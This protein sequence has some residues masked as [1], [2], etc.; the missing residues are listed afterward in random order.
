MSH[1][2]STYY[3]NSVYLGNFSGE[4]Y[5]SPLTI[6]TTGVIYPEPFTL[7]SGL[8]GAVTGY[9]TVINDGTIHGGDNARGYYFRGIELNGIITN[10]GLIQ[11]G[12]GYLSS[13]ASG[14]GGDG[15]QLLGGGTVTNFGTI[16]GGMN[17]T[18]AG[19]GVG[20]DIQGVITNFGTVIGG[21]AGYGVIINGGTIEASGGDAVNGLGDSAVVIDPGGV[22]IGEVLG[23]VLEVSGTSAET[24]SGIGTQFLDF[25]TIDF[26]L[27]AA[28]AIEG[29]VTALDSGQVINGFSLNDTIFAS[30]FAATSETYVANT[31]LEI[32]DGT[33]TATLD[34]IGSFST[35]LFVVTSAG[36]QTEV[37]LLCYL[38]STNIATPVGEVPVETLKIGDAVITRFSG[39][40]KVKWIGR[41]SFAARFV[42]N[43]RDQI[44]VRFAIGALGPNLPKRDLFVSPGHSMLIGGV[45]VLARNLVN[46]VTITQDDLPEEIHYYQLEFEGHDC[47][48]AEGAW[49]ESFCDY[50]GLRNQFHNVDSFY[51][52]YPDHVTPDEHRMCAP[53]PEAGP[54]LEAALLPVVQRATALAVPGALHGWI[55]IVDTFGRVEGWAQDTANPELPVLLDLMVNSEK[56]GRTLACEYRVDLAAAGLGKGC[57]AFAFDAAAE[58][59][60]RASSNVQVRR[61]TDMAEIKMGPHCLASLG[62]LNQPTRASAES[63]AYRRIG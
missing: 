53:R 21:V 17:A 57:C 56:R 50:A 55:D 60:F 10:H 39:Y 28:W 5:R 26:N 62:V 1:T 23:D 40:Q 22:F 19:H 25:H 7:Y 37:E 13:G 16:V 4:Q 33:A 36:D 48:L 54:M 58:M 44:P 34:I 12:N 3:G 31:G 6:T 35:G 41:Q 61:S 32:S 51:L 52:L 8:V 14:L 18:G 49:S 29:T 46:G 20:I 45:L 47:V 27:G 9:G 43:N 24:L 63:I 59:P 2:I 11:G 15:V 42:K 38:R 30:G